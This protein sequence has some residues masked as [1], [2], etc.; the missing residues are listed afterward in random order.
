MLLVLSL[1]GWEQDIEEESIKKLLFSPED[2][3]DLRWTSYIGPRKKV[4]PHNGEV[5]HLRTKIDTLI[6]ANIS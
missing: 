3:L 4:Y 5:Y 1:L 2:F 6:A